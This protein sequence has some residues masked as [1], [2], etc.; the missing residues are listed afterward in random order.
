[1]KDKVLAALR[2]LLIVCGILT[3]VVLLLHARIIYA[4][5]T[6][7]EVPEDACPWLEGLKTCKCRKSEGA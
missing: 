5:L 6:G 2:W 3:L 7:G 1:M 4:K